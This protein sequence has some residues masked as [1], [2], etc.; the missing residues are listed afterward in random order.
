V[1]PSRA[2]SSAQYLETRHA[3]RLLDHHPER[4]GYQL[5]ERVSDVAV[6]IDALNRIAEGECVI[7]PT[8][9]SRLVGRSHHGPLAELTE[10]ERDVLALMAEGH[11]NQ[12]ICAKL[13]LSPRRPA[14][15]F[16]PQRGP[17][18]NGVT[19]LNPAW[20]SPIASV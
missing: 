7:D 3:P 4:V 17:S 8:I 14:R 19:P 18:L 13:Y 5:K 1:S 10:R 2:A 9:V 12:G 11:S 6:L 16:R 20:T 15:S